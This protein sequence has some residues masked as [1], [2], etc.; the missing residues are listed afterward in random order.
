M[1]LWSIHPKYLD[2][3]GLVAL[4]RETLLAQKVLQGQTKGYRNHPQLERFKE[5]KDPVAAIGC[6]LTYIYDEAKT[7]GYNFSVEKIVNLYRKS[8]G[9]TV[10]QGQLDYE[11]QHLKQ[12]VEKRDKIIFE[13]IKFIKNPKSH[14]LFR[15]IKGEMA[16]WEKITGI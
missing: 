7:R 13:K 1:R 3:K 5:C 8:A 10:T 11:F 2:A 9:M 15:V 16:S 14:P 12:K 6:Y 4:W